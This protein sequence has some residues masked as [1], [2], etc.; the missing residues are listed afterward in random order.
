MLKAWPRP[1]LPPARGSDHGSPQAEIS[2]QCK[3]IS[4]RKR[5]R[6]RSDSRNPRRT[7]ESAERAQKDPESRLIREAARQGDYHKSPAG[8]IACR[9]LFYA[10][11][12]VKLCRGCPRCPSG[13]GVGV[14]KI[15]PPGLLCAP[16]RAFL[17]V[18]IYLYY[19][20]RLRPF[21]GVSG[22]SVR[23]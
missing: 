20:A 2:G 10:L 8:L 21:W 12:G 22:A 23:A 11:G 17:C 3:R 6:G 16:W 13:C 5:R 9:G 1:V 14:V 4:P 19:P 18:Q 15:C 7:A